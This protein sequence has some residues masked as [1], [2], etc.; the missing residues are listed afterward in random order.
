M[1]FFAGLVPSVKITADGYLRHLQCIIL[2][3]ETGCKAQTPLMT[4]LVLSYLNVSCLL[5]IFSLH[6]DVL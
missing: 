6:R 5:L 4:T 3:Y 1:A 2:Q